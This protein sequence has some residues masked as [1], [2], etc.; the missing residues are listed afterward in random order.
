MN[1]D[2]EPQ[3]A[4]SDRPGGR[5]PML[6]ASLAVVLALVA[7]IVSVA[8]FL[9]AGDK[10]VAVAVASTAAPTTSPAPGPTTTAAGPSV[11]AEPTTEPIEEPTAEPT[12]GPDPS[13]SFTVAY[14]KKPLRLQPSSARSIDLDLPTANAGSATGEL[15]YIGGVPSTKL[16]FFS[17]SSI[18]EVNVPAPTANDCAQQLRQAPIDSDVAPSKGQQLCALTSADRSVSQGI[19]QKI[20]LIRIDAIA[21]DGT[22]N[23]TVSAWNVPR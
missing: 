15:Q 19:R 11:T 10:D 3:L 8:A 1:P 16:E 5:T 12:D 4:T 6:F 17:G 14:E 22:L 9:R 21:S 7:T 20:V 23:V 18:A 2:F 13:A